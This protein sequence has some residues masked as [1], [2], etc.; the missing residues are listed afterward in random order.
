MPYIKDKVMLKAVGIPGNKGELIQSKEQGRKDRE[1]QKACKEFEALFTYQLLKSMR[2]TVEKC[3]LFHGGQGE[4]IYE[5]L[6]DLELSKQMAD[7]GPNSLSRMLYEQLKREDEK[8][9]RELE[10]ANN[11]HML[12]KKTR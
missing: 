3:D 4:E 10:K 6:F 5:S 1:L 12:T 8:L 2:R 11:E 7:M 9:Q